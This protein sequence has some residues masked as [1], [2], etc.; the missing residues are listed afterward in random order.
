[1]RSD[2]KSGRPSLECTRSIR[3]VQ[4]SERVRDST[5]SRSFLYSCGLVISSR[6]WSG[7]GEGEDESETSVREDEVESSWDSDAGLVLMHAISV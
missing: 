1:M 5:V 2:T 3:W 6:T 4:N 7:A